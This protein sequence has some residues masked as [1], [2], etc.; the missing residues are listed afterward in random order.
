[1]SG[2]WYYS[3]A[4]VTHGPFSLDEIKE[5]LT[6]KMLLESDWVWQ[7]GADV[8][9]RAADFLASAGT[10][11]VPDWLA[12]VAE[13]EKRGAPSGSTAAPDAP[14]WL[15]DLRLWIALEQF[16]SGWE[17]FHKTADRPVSGPGEGAGIPDW[18][19]SWGI[20]AA[21]QE[22]APARPASVAAP[23]SAPP[24]KPQ[25]DV[26]PLLKVARPAAAP[27]VAKAPP[28][29]KVPTP[30]A[31]PAPE[32]KPAVQERTRTPGKQMLEVSGFDSET[33]QIVDEAK[34]RL[35]KQKQAQ[36]SAASQ[37]AVSNAS[38]FEVFRRGR[39]AIEAWVDDEAN[40][41]CVLHG[42]PDEIQRNREVQA[43][44]AAYA[45]YGQAIQE[46][47]L[48]HLKFMVNNRRKYYR[49]LAERG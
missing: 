33:G 29:L 26:P 21:P 1:M 28:V 18:L 23:A 39:T 22:S 8:R 25:V 40:R 46:K 19:A 2:P 30:A 35:W 48:A 15:E 7:E 41:L 27:V 10:P 47:L 17:A 9:R 31:A 42:E 44:L 14:E 6:R 16:E 45:N 5:R 38:L 32:T 36:P 20:P 13:F 49:A 11:P 12:D 34:F 24:A 3:H 37:P 43:I 4:E